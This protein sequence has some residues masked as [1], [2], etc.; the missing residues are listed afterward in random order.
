MRTK[1][2]VQTLHGGSTWDDIIN[3]YVATKAP[4]YKTLEFPPDFLRIL[5][6]ACP[7]LIIVGRLYSQRWDER[8]GDAKD[9]C[10]WAMDW[11]DGLQSVVDVLEG[12]NESH[13]STSKLDNYA[14]FEAERTRLLN[15]HGFGS[16]VGNFSTGQPNIRDW[17][18]FYPAIEAAIKYNGF[19][20]LHEYSAPTADWMY[21]KNQWNWTTNIPWDVHDSD[22][23]DEGSTGWLTFRYL[24][25]LESLPSYLKNVKIIVT[26]CLI[27]GGIQ[28]RPGLQGGG[29]KDFGDKYWHINQIAWYDRGIRND[30]NVV[31][32]TLFQVSD[33]TYSEWEGFNVIDMLPEVQDYGAELVN[34]T[35]VDVQ[36][37]DNSIQEGTVSQSGKNMEWLLDNVAYNEVLHL[38]QGASLQEKIFSD[39]FSP[40]SNEFT[41]VDDDGTIYRVQY[42]R[43]RHNFLRAYYAKWGEWDKVMCV[44]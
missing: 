6:A 28:P 34:P 9:W 18:L 10:D 11:V 29:W 25:V 16:V 33:P 15:D 35:E 44:F 8:L 12:P 3:Y 7:D 43:D 17:H 40:T 19:L 30:P 31:G 24:K 42:A 14:E 22:C 41:E 32:A 27:D 38:V 1:I 21:G 2:G 20:G 36:A 5:R 26:E 37:N 39:G 23:P 13:Q 4:V